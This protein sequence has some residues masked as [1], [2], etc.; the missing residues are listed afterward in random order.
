MHI[1]KNDF[2]KNIDSGKWFKKG[3][4]LVKFKYSNDNLIGLWL[5]DYDPEGMC[6]TDQANKDWD[7][8]D[9]KIIDYG[10]GVY[11]FGSIEGEI[12]SIYNEETGEIIVDKMK[13]IILNSWENKYYN[14]V[15]KE[16]LDNIWDDII[17]KNFNKYEVLL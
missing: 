3:N 5:S 15:T 17:N 12:D 1:N 11:H 2:I 8:K 16:E 10:A 13:S 4:Y 9:G 7:I 14:V 6:F